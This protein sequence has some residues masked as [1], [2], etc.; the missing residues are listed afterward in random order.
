MNNS[1]QAQRAVL[2]AGAFLLALI[3]FNGYA[4]AKGG[5]RSGLKCAGSTFAHTWAAGLLT[6]GLAVA[7]DWAPQIVVPF[8]FAVVVGYTYANPGLLTRFISN[9]SSKTPAHTTTHT[10]P[11]GVGGTY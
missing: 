2:F 7:A 6:L 1:S 10:G 11:A 4:C 8:A 5:G 3:W 9:E